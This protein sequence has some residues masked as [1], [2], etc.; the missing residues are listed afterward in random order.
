MSYHTMA[1]SYVGPSICVQA[2]STILW[3]FSEILVCRRTRSRWIESSNH[4]RVIFKTITKILTLIWRYWWKKK[5][6]ELRRR[7]EHSPACRECL[8][9]LEFN[10]YISQPPLAHRLWAHPASYP[11]DTWGGGVFLSIKRPE[12]DH[13]SAQ[14]FLASALDDAPSAFGKSAPGAYWIGAEWSPELV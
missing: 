14:A 1:R 10:R 13:S 9:V 4:Y 6:L 2:Y 11:I 5:S 12:R 7:G 3:F 8:T